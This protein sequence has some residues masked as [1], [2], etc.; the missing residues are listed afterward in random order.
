MYIFLTTI[1]VMLIW[2]FPNV[3][4]L[5]I[6]TY[7]TYRR[8]LGRLKHLATMKH[9]EEN[10]EE[11][12]PDNSKENNIVSRRSL[13][14][15]I[16]HSLRIYLTCVVML[17][18]HLYLSVFQLLNK[19]IIKINKNTY[20]LTYILNDNTYKIL[21]KTN[22][23]PQPKIIQAIDELDQD[24]TESL[25]F[26]F[27][28]VGNFHGIKYKPKDFNIKKLTLNMGDTRELV[29]DQNDE[30]ILTDQPPNLFKDTVVEMLKYIKPSCNDLD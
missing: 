3:L 25:R 29:F 24:I 27:G 19:S 2:M 26:Y 22:L 1:L 18:N 16:R 12:S 10:S 11:N 8:K 14:H 23:G 15:S 17:M 28:P 13:R 7:K 30:I 20:S 5:S 6:D 9:S 4:Y 21:I